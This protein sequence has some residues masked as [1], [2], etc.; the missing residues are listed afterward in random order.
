ME[1]ADDEGVEKSV[2]SWI[3]KILSSMT[4]R[5]RVWV[6][7]G[8]FASL[9]ILKEE[10][11]GMGLEESRQTIEL[12]RRR[13]QYDVMG[14]DDVISL[15]LIGLLA[16]GHVLLEDF[17]GSGKTTLAKALGNS[18]STTPSDTLAAFRRMQFTPDLLPGDITGVMVFDPEANVFEFRQGPIFAHIVLVDEINRTSPK[19]QS[20]LLESMGEKQVTVDNVTHS[21]SDLFFVIAT[22]NPLDQVGTYPLPVA[23]LDRFMFKIRMTHISREA[24]MAVIRSWGRPRAKCDMEKVSVQSILEARAYV[25]SSVAVDDEVMGCLVDMIRKLREDGRC[26]QGAS[27]RSLVQAVSALQAHAFLAGRSYVSPEDIESL[28]L[29]LF[30][31]RL[32]LA[33]GVGNADDLVR[34]ALSEPLRK[35]SSKSLHRA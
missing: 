2:A 3:K 33:P 28:A 6:L 32:Q 8:A 22:Q 9:W 25:V 23:Q 7:S 16:D 20:A 24:E 34:E 10:R 29:P 31:H 15:V 19:V 5:I 14:R 12:L 26:L 30:S 17:P 35:L 1:R 27:T 11:D 13:M 4:K 18:I 21:L